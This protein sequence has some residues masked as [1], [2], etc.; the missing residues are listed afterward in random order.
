MANAIKNCHLVGYTVEGGAGLN[1]KSLHCIEMTQG[2]GETLIWFGSTV[3]GERRVQGRTSA[4]L[5]PPKS[6]K[7]D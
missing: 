1:D 2:V 3:S 4:A 7:I 6:V 5:T